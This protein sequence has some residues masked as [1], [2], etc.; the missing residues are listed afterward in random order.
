[1][2]YENEKFGSSRFQDFYEIKE[3]YRSQAGAVYSARFKFDKN[4]YVLKERTFPELGKRKDIM[5]EVNLL[6]QLD[7]PN[8]VKC[9]G[10]F[11]DPSRNSL[12]IILEYCKNGDLKEIV[13]SYRT[14]GKYLEEGFIW[15]IFC[16]LCDGLKHMHANGI[17]HRDLK[18]MNIMVV[19]K[20]CKKTG[21]PIKFTVKLADLGVS[22]QLSEETMM[23]QTVYGTP[24]Y[25]SPELVE[26][27]QYNEKTDIWSLGVILY[28]LAALKHPFRSNTLLGL[29]R[30]VVK[31]TYEDVPSQYSRQLRKCL[32]WM[33]N[34]DFSKRPN[35]TQL[36]K[37][38][39][40]R[41]FM[42]RAMAV[43]YS[44]LLFSY[45]ISS[46]ALESPDLLLSYSVILLAL[47]NT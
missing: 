13:D 37:F 10:F 1:M 43:D 38:V 31:G 8:V 46:G 17:V 40:D 34:L 3:L 6:A 15:H 22:R 18:P 28:E 27:K 26:N 4:K 21:E 35:V 39:E 36:H 32:S 45:S 41:T 42:F 7:H 16:Q 9:E 30:A 44:I 23:L 25:L 47:H 2:V 14:K 29:A 5:N 11:R 20:N 19:T 33:L 24:L 12:F